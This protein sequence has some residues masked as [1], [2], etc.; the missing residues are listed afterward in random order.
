MFSEHIWSCRR[1][2]ESNYVS[3]C[4]RLRKKR[5][6]FICFS[7]PLFP[8]QSSP[9]P[10]SHIIPTSAPLLLFSA[11]L[12][13]W[14]AACILPATNAICWKRPS[15][16]TVHRAALSHHHS[17]H[18]CVSFAKPMAL[19]RSLLP[20]A[21][22]EDCVCHCSCSSRHTRSIAQHIVGAWEISAMWMDGPWR[23]ASKPLPLLWFLTD[24]SSK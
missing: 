12:F 14:L 3:F 22:R 9:P 23:Y 8:L 1:T 21:G 6:I 11:H 18:S 4:I 5:D 17:R 15:L 16:T 7:A 2:V 20:P 10:S 24:S 13:A 19:V